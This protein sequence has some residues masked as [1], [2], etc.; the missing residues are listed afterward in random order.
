MS[1]LGSGIDDCASPW[2][3]AEGIPSSRSRLPRLSLSCWGLVRCPHSSPSA[4]QEGGET[5]LCLVSWTF[6]CLPLLSV[7]KRYHPCKL[8]FP[9]SLATGFLFHLTIGYTDRRADDGIKGEARVFL[10]LSAPWPVAG[11][12]P[13][14]PTPA[15]TPWPH[16]LL[17][18]SL[19]PGASCCG[20]SLGCLLICPWLFGSS[21]TTIMSFLY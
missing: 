18:V 12:F 4:L 3:S 14:V 2:E 15:W 10:G 21:N 20:S 8:H 7:V 13:V 5:P 9:G 11:V 6:A 19:Q 1:D 16:G 17:P